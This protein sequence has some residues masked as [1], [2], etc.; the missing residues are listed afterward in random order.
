MAMEQS[1]EKGAHE[2]ALTEAEYVLLTYADA[3]GVLRVRDSWNPAKVD[4]ASDSLVAR[5]YLVAD[6]DGMLRI[7]PEGR[8]AYDHQDHAERA[9]TE[10]GVLRRP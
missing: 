4:Q 9:M 7:T 6:V 5:G 8:A 10:T 2:G 1:H 3:T